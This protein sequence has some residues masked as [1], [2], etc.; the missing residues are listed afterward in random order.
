VGAPLQINPFITAFQNRA[1][2]QLEGQV[3]SAKIALARLSSPLL[4]FVL[5]G[6]DFSL[7]IN[8]PD[9]PKIVILANNPEK[10]QIYGAVISLYLNRVFRILPKKNRLKC[11]I[12][13]DEFSSIF[14]NGIENFLAIARG[15]KINTYLAVQNLAQLRKSYG[16]EHAD[17]LFSLAGNVI[18]GQATGE[19][20]KE[21]SEIIGKI[22][23]TRES[24]S[25]NR[26]DTSLSKS[27][28]LEMAVPPARI[29]KLSS[30]EF[31]GVLADNPDQKL[32]QKAFYC[33]IQNDP[34]S[35]NL[36][37]ANYHPL[38]Q[39]KVSQVAIQNNFI[40]VKND[41]TILINSEL[42]RIKEDPELAYLLLEK[43]NKKK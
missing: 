8:N 37:E 34:A 35:I 13:A 41:V 43:E 20:A 16:K 26:Q 33:T 18:S 38:P 1:L 28:Q 39:R 17:V 11:A 7:D 10:T 19:T 42:N 5:S 6:N 21:V 25:I 2:E 30:G 4:Y 31:V 24:I 3:G 40:Q 36:E 22:V 15:Y 27:T 9:E 14:A 12:I 32:S 23:Q 29:A